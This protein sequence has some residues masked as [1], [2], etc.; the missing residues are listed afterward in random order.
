MLSHGAGSPWWLRLLLRCGESLALVLIVVCLGVV[1][2]AFAALI[3]L[4]VLR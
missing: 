4:E 1:V 2:V 3:V